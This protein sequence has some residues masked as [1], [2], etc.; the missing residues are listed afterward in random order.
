[1]FG[2]LNYVFLARCVEFY[3]FWRLVRRM[4]LWW[5]S[6]ACAVGSKIGH[7]QLLAISI[8]IFINVVKALVLVSFRFSI[9]KLLI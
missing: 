6:L 7:T 1:M 3:R 9:R 8:L 5:S 2:A 4:L